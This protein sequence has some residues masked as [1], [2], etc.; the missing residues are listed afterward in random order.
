MRA[1]CD[2]Y[3]LTC[4]RDAALPR[5]AAILARQ[6]LTEDALPALDASLA[7]LEAEFVPHTA[8]L[9]GAATVLSSSGAPLA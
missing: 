9:A 6:V 4:I 1:L 3:C 5:L 7:S 2:V 8:G